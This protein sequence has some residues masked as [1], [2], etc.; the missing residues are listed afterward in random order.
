M[1]AAAAGLAAPANI[2]TTSKI[3]RSPK[4][5]TGMIFRNSGFLPARDHCLDLGEG[6]RQ[7]ETLNLRTQ[8]SG[9]LG[10][11]EQAAY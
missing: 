6:M 3:Q 4:Y 9:D 2:D 5:K 8:L 7:F 1:N 11:G 10:N